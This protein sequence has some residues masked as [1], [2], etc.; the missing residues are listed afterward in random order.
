MKRHPLSQEELSDSLL[1]KLH[2]SL[3]I[4]VA[5]FSRGHNLTKSLL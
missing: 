4:W 1:D 2:T 3:T 5:K